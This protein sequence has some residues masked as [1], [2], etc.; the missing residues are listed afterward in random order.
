LKNYQLPDYLSAA[1]DVSSEIDAIAR[2]K[3]HEY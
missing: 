3:D 1:E 2:W